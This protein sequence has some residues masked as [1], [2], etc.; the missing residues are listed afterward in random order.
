MSIKQACE[1]LL[2][3]ANGRDADA[4]K[5]TKEHK[6]VGLAR[7]GQPDQVI[8]AGTMEELMKVDFGGP[9]HSLVVAGKM[10]VVE[11]EM[12]EF[13]SV[14]KVEARMKRR[15]ELSAKLNAESDDTTTTAAA[16]PDTTTT[17]SS[18]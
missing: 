9:L 5:L 1:L 7:V 3:I 6:C 4:P 13:L 8:A 14:Q 10:H 15:A 2:K 17:E 18:E 16:A 11:E 12:F